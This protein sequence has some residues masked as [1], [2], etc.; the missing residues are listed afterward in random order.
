[1]QS[2]YCLS[3]LA[4]YDY[5]TNGKRPIKDVLRDGVVFAGKLRSRLPQSQAQQQSNPKSQGAASVFGS[6][7]WTRIALV[8]NVCGAILLF[9]SFQATSSSFRLIRR[10][11][12]SALTHDISE[13]SICVEDYTLLSTD[14]RRGIFMGHSGC[15]TAQ[16]DRRAAVVNTE[17]PTF[18]T[19]GFLSIV[20]GFIIQFFA[21]PEPRTIAQLRQEIKLLKARETS[22]SPK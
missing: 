6:Q 22:N 8:L 19:I 2:R 5:A 15:P 14:A 3:A 11:G 4:C 16:D 12:N 1:M 10:T 21:V 20:A 17:H 9:Y 13:Y 18:V 7:K